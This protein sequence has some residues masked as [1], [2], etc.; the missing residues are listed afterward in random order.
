MCGMQESNFKEIVLWLIR[1]RH[2]YRV[3]GVSMCPLISADDE[4]FV[5][6]H[7]YRCRAPQIGD[8]VIARHPAQPGLQI[9]KRIT[10]IRG[11]GCY[12]LQGDNPD[13]SQNSQSWVASQMIIGRVTSRFAS[14]S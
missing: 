10:K 1:L 2:R 9:V 12:H 13:L 5:D 4:I 6:P 7:A 8:V 14:A 3:T 11:S